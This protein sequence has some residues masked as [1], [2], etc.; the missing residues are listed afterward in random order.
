M[1][2]LPPKAPRVGYSAYYRHKSEA[3]KC[4]EEPSSTNLGLTRIASGVSWLDT[5]RAFVVHRTTAGLDTAAAS[6]R[7]MLVLDGNAFLGYNQ[8]GVLSRFNCGHE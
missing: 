7:S 1:A 5:R 6:S 2:W 3:V 8:V 4:Q